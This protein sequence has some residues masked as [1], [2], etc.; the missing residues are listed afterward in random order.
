MYSS[1]L[2][3]P[4][5]HMEGH[6]PLIF[7]FKPSY[8]DSL[9]GKNPDTQVGLFSDIFREKRPQRPFAPTPN[10]AKK[11]R[12]VEGYALNLQIET[13]WLR[14]HILEPHRSEI[15]TLPLINLLPL[16]Q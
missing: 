12:G 1:Y 10:H 2:G 9:M 11:V 4:R 5:T 15:P 7:I 16:R 3:E 13:K 14:E 8:P 6:K